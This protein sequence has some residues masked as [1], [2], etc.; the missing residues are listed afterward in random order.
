[1][2]QI[3]KNTVDNDCDSSCHR[4]SRKIGE[5]I[6]RVPQATSLRMDDIMQLFSFVMEQ[7]VGSQ[8]HGSWGN[9]LLHVPRITEV[10]VVGVQFV[11]YFP[12]PQI[13]DGTEEVI[14]AIP[15]PQLMEDSVE[16]IVK[17]TVDNDCDFVNSVVGN[18]CEFVNNS[19]RLRL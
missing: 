5:A 15:V 18:A 8:C 19:R 3:V 13:M 12:V 2:E 11:P 9:S 10:L 4:P 1:M 16:Q 7:I 17:N 14:V 6:Q